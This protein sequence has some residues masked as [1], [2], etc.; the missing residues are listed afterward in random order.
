MGAALAFIKAGNY[1]A[2]VENPCYIRESYL[3]M[4]EIW[5]IYRKEGIHAERMMPTMLYYLPLQLVVPISQK[6]YNTPLSKRVVEGHVY[7]CRSEHYTMYY[8][9]KKELAAKNEHSKWLDS[10]QRYIEQYWQE[11]CK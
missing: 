6:M 10:Y 5:K 7:R 11:G 8:E 4:R 3:L 2:Y 9:I 1:K